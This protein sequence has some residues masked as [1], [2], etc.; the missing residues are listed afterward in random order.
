MQK[1]YILARGISFIGVIALSVIG[2]FS[3]L[4]LI[5][6]IQ[7]HHMFI[8]R[9]SP[10]SPLFISILIIF[11][12]WT[13]IDLFRVKIWAVIASALCGAF[14][15]STGIDWIYSVNQLRF[16]G[17]LVNGSGHILIFLGAA[18]IAGSAAAYFSRRLRISYSPPDNRPDVPQSEPV[19]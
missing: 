17:D 8:V 18:C 16:D 2:A 12:L 15:I 5:S 6:S 13:A 10:F 11:F 14:L 7:L 1:F 3:L 4:L 9:I 19:P